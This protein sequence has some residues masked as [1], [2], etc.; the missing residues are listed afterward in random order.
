MSKETTKIDIELIKEHR[1]TSENN[2]N[3]MKEEFNA[4]ELQ[5]S[6]NKELSEKI[7]GEMISLQGE[8]RA[9]TKLINDSEKNK[10]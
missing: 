10:D 8:W 1:V 3:K 9:L 5:I 6:K 4:C 7:K 2:F